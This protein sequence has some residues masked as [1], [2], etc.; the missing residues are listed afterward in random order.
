ME[1][2]LITAIFRLWMPRPQ[3]NQWNQTDMSCCRDLYEILKKQVFCH[4]TICL[5]FLKIIHIHCSQHF[6]KQNYYYIISYQW[7]EP[8]V[9][10]CRH[11]DINIIFY[12]KDIHTSPSLKKGYFSCFWFGIHSTSIKKEY[13]TMSLALHTKLDNP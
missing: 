4:S 11:L 7:S 1:P 10:I 12:H 2:Q 13:E 9:F 3:S 5:H 8:C 6:N